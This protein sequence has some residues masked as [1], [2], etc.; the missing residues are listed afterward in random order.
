[1]NGRNEKQEMNTVVLY[2][3]FLKQNIKQMFENE[4]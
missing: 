3:F 4:R 2:I 1:M